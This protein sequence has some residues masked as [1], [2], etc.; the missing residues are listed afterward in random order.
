MG[1]KNEIVT[2]TIVNAGSDLSK[3]LPQEALDSIA[4]DGIADLPAYDESRAGRRQMGFFPLPKVEIEHPASRDFS[5]GEDAIEVA[6]PAK[7][8]FG[9][10]PLAHVPLSASFK[11]AD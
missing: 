6:L 10:Q 8:V 3:R 2:V 4:Y 5:V 1:Y 7:P 11:D 9:A